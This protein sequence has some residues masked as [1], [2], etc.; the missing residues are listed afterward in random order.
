MPSQHLACQNAQIS[1]KF[2]H[3]P[4]L[5]IFS[6][7]FQIFRRNWAQLRRQRLRADESLAIDNAH[8][9]IA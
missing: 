7:N 5:M 6:K 2:D 9:L 1:R 8:H 3:K 4:S